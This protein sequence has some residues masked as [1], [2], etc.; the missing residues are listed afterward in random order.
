M[1]IKFKKTNPDAILPKRNHDN[2]DGTGDT[3][4]DVYSVEDKVIPARG[5]AV[6]D[7][8][9]EFAYIEPHYW[10]KI[11]GRS[12]LGFKHDIIP[13]G[14]I[15]DNCV[16]KGTKIQTLDGPIN[17]EDLYNNQQLPNIYSYNEE[18]MQND[19]DK[20]SEMW[21]VPNVELLEVTTIEGESVKIPPDKLIYTKRGWIKAKDLNITDYVLIF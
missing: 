19:I 21:I 12:G 20:I 15:V 17:V 4:Y 11:E 13:H 10:I 6:V 18:T 5:S 9:L 1:I 2:V 7:V 8:G 16:P 3:G 14:G